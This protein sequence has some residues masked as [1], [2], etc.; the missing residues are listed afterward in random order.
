MDV[1]LS[2]RRSRPSRH[3]CVALQQFGLVRRRSGGDL[4]DQA[5]GTSNGRR[6]CR[7]RH[8]PSE[9]RNHSPVRN[10]PWMRAFP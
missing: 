4:F 1:G 5:I 10:V 2:P 6:G 3:L 8:D 7:K 9:L